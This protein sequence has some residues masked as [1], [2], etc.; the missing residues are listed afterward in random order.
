MGR[1]AQTSALRR[2]T[3][4]EQ[5][6]R[7][8]ALPAELTYV[9]T[10]SCGHVGFIPYKFDVKW[11]HLVFS[12]VLNRQYERVWRTQLNRWWEGNEFPNEIIPPVLAT[13]GFF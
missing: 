1:A 13:T 8:I 10:E 2:R 5:Y 3:V 4:V 12:L 7:P 11:C 6:Q 9:H